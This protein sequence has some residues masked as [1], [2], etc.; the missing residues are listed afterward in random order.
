MYRATGS[1]LS[2]SYSCS[3]IQFTYRDACLK[4]IIMHT[5]LSAFFAQTTSRQDAHVH[6]SSHPQLASNHAAGRLQAG[7][8][9]VPEFAI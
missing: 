1:K 5:D 8:A 3:T 7:M 2:K 6:D 9:H 4:V